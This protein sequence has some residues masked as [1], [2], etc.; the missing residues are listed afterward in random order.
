MQEEVNV[1]LIRAMSISACKICIINSKWGRNWQKITHWFYLSRAD[2]ILFL[3]S[4]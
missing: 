4:L 1:R 2:G 3:M